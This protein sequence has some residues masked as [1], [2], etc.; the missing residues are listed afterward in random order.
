[1]ITWYICSPSKIEMKIYYLFKKSKNLD[2]IFELTNFQKPR[3][4]VTR[5]MKKSPK[6]R[7]NIMLINV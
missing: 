6:S 1:M 7:P 2:F 4:R 5:R 3:L